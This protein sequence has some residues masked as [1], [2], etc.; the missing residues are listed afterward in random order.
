MMKSAYFIIAISLATICTTPL[1]ASGESRSPW[2]IRVLVLRYFPVQDGLIDINITGDWGESLEATQQKTERLTQE[3]IAAL[4]DGSRYHGYKNPKSRASVRYSVVETLDFLQPM[5]TLKKRG[6]KVPMTDYYEIMKHIDIENWV[7]EKG[8]KEVWIWGY[9]GG[10]IDLWESNMAGPHGDISNSDRDPKDLPKLKKTYTVY[11]YNYQ[12]G[13]SEAIENHMHQI[14]HLLN[15]VDGRDY[16]PPRKWDR[17]L[18]W[19]KFV[20]SD[21]SHKIVNPG[22]GWA[23][24]PPNAERDYDWAN[25]R[26]VWSDIE[27]WQP[28]GQS[29]K[30]RINCDKWEGNSLKWFVYWMQNLP[31][32]D[33]G[34]IYK[35]KPLLNWWIFIGDFDYAMQKQMKLIAR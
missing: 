26:Y 16:T 20:G 7:I 31:G 6:H 23:H 12:R 25:P 10:K 17:L 1:P 33:S 28:D 13:T 2:E 15:W 14:E 29:K 18:F 27:D 5:P 3:T 9:H 8:V 34:L 24:Y 21:S 35:S 11:H 30:Q 22:C 4:E 32:L 19:G